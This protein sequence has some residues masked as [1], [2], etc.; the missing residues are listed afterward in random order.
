MNYTI[1]ELREEEYYLLEDFLYEA[2]FQPDETDLVPKSIIYKPELHIYIEHFGEKT[3]DFCLCAEVDNKVVGA[4]WVRNINGYGKVDEVTP[5][6]AISLYKD[7]RGYGIGTELMQEMLKH[8]KQAGH[9]KVSL[10]VQKAN[11]A[12]NLYKKVG[13]QIVDE[14][15]EEYI[16]V[17]SIQ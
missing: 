13:F 10:A 3:E 17:R 14:N 11:Y 1:R 7:F 8:L 5:E 9:I 6:F 2:I 4:V 15:E 12:R 16:M